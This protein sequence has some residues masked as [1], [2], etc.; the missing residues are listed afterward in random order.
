MLRS[1]LFSA[2]AASGLAVALSAQAG[3]VEDMRGLL[4]Q[5][6]AKE[7]YAIGQQN[8][9]LLG[10]PDFDFFYGLAAIE[11]GH[12]A[13]GILAL[14]RYLL[15]NPDNARA[16]LELARGYFVLGDDVRAREEF[17]AVRKLKPPASVLAAIDRFV[18]AIRTREGRYQTTAS[19]YA[20]AGFG[21]DTNVN[22][23]ASTANITLPVFGAVT[24]SDTGVEKRDSFGHF[25]LGGQA[26]KPVAP[27][28]SLF[29]AAGFDGR[30]NREESAFNQ[31]SLGLTGGVS[32]VKDNDLYRVGLNWN[33]ATV[34]SEHYRDVLGVSGEWFRQLDEF[35]A[36]NAFV[37]YA[38]L[39]YGGA[40]RVRDAD[41]KGVGVG[42]RRAFS[43]KWQPVVSARLSYS[44]ES[45]QKRR[46]DF[47]RD[48]PGLNLGVSFSPD[49]KWGL[50]VNY[51][52]QKSNYDG[53]MLG[54]DRKD[55][56]QSLG[57]NATFLVDKQVSLRGELS[58][59]ENESNIEL[60]SNKRT[61]A[62][63]NLRYDFK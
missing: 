26:A 32:Y 53:K 40:N 46:P 20:E 17:E 4:G 35:Q 34:G 48:M 31:A 8:P 56:Y 28:V 19:F 45:N 23:G 18:D 5:N 47:S 43:V 58:Y 63:V 49:P 21:I 2:L 37:Q 6:Q 60:Y 61:L 51:A 7:A 57:L 10:E 22:G 25:A 50:G 16:R 39:E 15:L 13:E 30:Y 44:K 11:A 52:Y 1:I 29:G 24:L 12:A 59:S 9:D 27:G 14:E 42:Y 41:L 54:V 3:P 55:S 38:D 33:G 62:A 36:V